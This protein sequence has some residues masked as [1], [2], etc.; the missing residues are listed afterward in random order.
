LTEA[1]VEAAAAEL[2][3]PASQ[4]AS[5]SASASSLSAQDVAPHANGVDRGASNAE[6]SDWPALGAPSRPPH[7]GPAGASAG[8]PDAADA[9]P[10]LGA[11]WEGRGAPS[12]QGSM[13]LRDPA[14]GSADAAWDDD[15]FEEPAADAEVAGGG[16]GAGGGEAS[17]GHAAPLAVVRRPC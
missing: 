2:R 16:G 4:T 15:D 7:G 17:N 3:P 1:A 5:R 10:R 11:A 14:G 6:P 13:A 9:Q 8:A 12:Q